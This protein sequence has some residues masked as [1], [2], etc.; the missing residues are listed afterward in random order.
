[1]LNRRLGFTPETDDRQ[2]LGALEVEMEEAGL[3]PAEAIPYLAPILSI[4]LAPEGPYPSP[5][6]DALKLRQTTID[7]FKS[8]WRG[9][10]A[11]EPRV[12]LDR[13]PPLGRTIDGGSDRADRRRPAARPAPGLDC[14]ARSS[15]ALEG[16][17][18][19]ITIDCHRW[20]NLIDIA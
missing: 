17:P 6:L 19:V 4:D 18:N 7:V 12:V 15:M 13:R 3:E 16:K 20:P 11:A 8:W 9:L 1:M 5:R 2:R 14:P 10:A